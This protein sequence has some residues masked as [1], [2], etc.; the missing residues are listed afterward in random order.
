MFFK[1]FLNFTL[2]I[3]CRIIKH[4]IK[5]KERKN[6]TFIIKFNQF[7]NRNSYQV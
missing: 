3:K 7:R 1:A 2:M 4:T 6:E 5:Q